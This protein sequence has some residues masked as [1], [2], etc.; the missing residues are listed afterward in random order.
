MGKKIV[1]LIILALLALGGYFLGKNIYYNK[2]YNYNKIVEEG[3][4]EY[5]KSNDTTDIDS[6]RD[7]LTL[8]ENNEEIRSDIKHI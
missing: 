2:I 4:E 5:Y 7:L 8:Y 1:L 6:I 3:M